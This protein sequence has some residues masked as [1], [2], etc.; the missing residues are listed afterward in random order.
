[1]TVSHSF[2]VFMPLTFFWEFLGVW[3]GCCRTSLKNGFIWG[4]LM[5]RLG[6]MGLGEDYHKGEVPFLSHG[7]G[8]GGTWYPYNNTKDSPML[9]PVSHPSRHTCSSIESPS[10]HPQNLVP[11]YLNWNPVIT[12]ILF[13]FSTKSFLLQRFVE[14]L[15]KHHQ[16]EW[17][18]QTCTLKKDIL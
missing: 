14:C 18:K 7:I 4:F 12:F 13:C 15:F 9:W 8:E 3:S 6:V 11:L 2:L 1:M 17:M 10:R 16:R 5:V